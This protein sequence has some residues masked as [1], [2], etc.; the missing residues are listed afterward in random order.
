MENQSVI[1]II[2]IIAALALLIIA[3]VKKAE[4]LLNFVMR[5]ILGTIGI[6]SVN[7]ILSAQ[8]I[9]CEVGIN[10]VTVLANAAL[11]FPGFVLLYGIRLME[12]L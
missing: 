1:F 5:G 12:F 4:W 9:P 8:N 10:A 7:S 6:F 2:I 3:M 11:G